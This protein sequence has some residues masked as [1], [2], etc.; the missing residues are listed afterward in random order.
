MDVF[1]DE[2]S[3]GKVRRDEATSRNGLAGCAAGFVT[4]LEQQGLDVLF[5][6]CVAGIGYVALVHAMGVVE[7]AEEVFGEKA[8]TTLARH[9]VVGGGALFGL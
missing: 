8:P 4:P 7:P 3:V 1:G 5:C 2:C 9:T 6:Q